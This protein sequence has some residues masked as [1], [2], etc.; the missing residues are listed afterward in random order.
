MAVARMERPLHPTLPSNSGVVFSRNTP[1]WR[2]LAAANAGLDFKPEAR[3]GQP[4]NWMPIELNYNNLLASGAYKVRWLDGAL[5]NHVPQASDEDW[6]S[7]KIVHLK[8]YRKE[9][10]VRK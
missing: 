7:R 4:G 10:P 9:W 6:S 8:G 3:A 1:F 5:Y 2:D